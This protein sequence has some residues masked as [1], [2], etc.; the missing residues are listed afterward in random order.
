MGLEGYSAQARTTALRVVA[1]ADGVPSNRLPGCRKDE[2]SGT[3][4]TNDSNRI[5][6]A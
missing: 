6:P 3:L 1:K 5:C 2:S 4:S